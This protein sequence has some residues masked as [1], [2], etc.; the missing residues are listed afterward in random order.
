MSKEMYLFMFSGAPASGKSTIAKAIATHFE[1]PY[2]ARDDAQR[3]LLQ[4]GLVTENTVHS[5]IWMLEMARVQLSVNVGCIL[6]GVFGKQSFRDKAQQIAQHFDAQFI[7]VHCFC[8]DV[9]LWKSRWYQRATTNHPAHW[10][11]PTWA[12]VEQIASRFEKWTHPDVIR[13][14]TVNSVEMNV[15]KITNNLN[16]G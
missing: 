15:S 2:F 11:N 5:Y 6:D 10:N 8:S 13:L 4:Q 12:D 9:T 7:P 16:F 3:F 1:V 14:N